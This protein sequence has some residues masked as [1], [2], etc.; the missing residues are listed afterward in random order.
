M[1]I[2]GENRAGGKVGQHRE[3][4]VKDLDRIHLSQR[5]LEQALLINQD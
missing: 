5:H 4:E 1:R 2:L 3:S